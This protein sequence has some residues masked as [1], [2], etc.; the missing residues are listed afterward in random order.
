MNSNTLEHRYIIVPVL[1]VGSHRISC[2]F[3]DEEGQIN[4]YE[5]QTHGHDS[6]NVIS[7]AI[8][9]VVE[10]R[11]AAYAFWIRGK[12]VAEFDDPNIYSVRLSNGVL[13]RKCESSRIRRPLKRRLR[14]HRWMLTML[15]IYNFILIF[16]R[17][18]FQYAGLPDTSCEH[19]SHYTV[20]FG[21][22]KDIQ[23]MCHC[24]T[25]DI[26][27]GTDTFASQNFTFEV[28]SL[29]DEW[30]LKTLSANET[31]TMNTMGTPQL[32]VDVM[33]FLMLLVVHA[34]IKTEAWGAF[35]SLCLSV[36]LSL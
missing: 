16:G 24:E 8:N 27:I 25:P 1:F 22:Q 30:T 9:D 33:V 18:S 29:S 34:I 28:N 35:F 4:D 13:E 17:V 21:L 36:S 11:P 7:Y 31:S 26:T 12:I 32:S 14:G 3:G 19:P 5:V 2:W 15:W 10:V 20:L 6:G 23:G